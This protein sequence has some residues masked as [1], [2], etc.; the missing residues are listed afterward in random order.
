MLRQF[1]SN[2]KTPEAE[3]QNGPVTVQLRK[4][5]LTVF[6]YPAAKSPPLGVVVFASGDGGWN[7]W[8]DTVSHALQTNGFTVLGINSADYAKTDYDL[9]TLQADY[10]T[11]AQTVLSKYP[12]SPPP[13]I[14][15]GWSMGAAQAVAVAGGPNPPRELIGV[16]I[17]SALSRGRYGL[18][19]SD[20]ADILPSGAGTFGVA[21]F[22]SGVNGLR[23]V[24]WHAGGDTVDSTAW[25]ANLRTPHREM[26]FPDADHGF[27][28]PD[29]KFLK[30]FVESAF[31]IVNSSL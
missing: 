29:P 13:L 3:F 7:N 20:Q 16:L 24:Q 14:V 6:E 11:I 4:R 5:P 19:I 12:A 15:G 25:L 26:D 23:I 18:R 8:E 2:S 30:Q 31:W 10:D 22:T 9:A 1:Q 27:N 28:G 17:A 21:D